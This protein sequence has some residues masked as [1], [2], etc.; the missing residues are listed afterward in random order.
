MD[1]AVVIAV[2]VARAFGA[3]LSPTVAAVVPVAPATAAAAGLDATLVTWGG[4][5]IAWYADALKEAR[6]GAGDHH[7][8]RREIVFA[9]CCA[10]SYLWEWSYGLL[11]RT[12]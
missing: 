11:R 3:A 9:V 8:R 6:V 7:E 2:P 12:G 4:F 1:G 10:E 5:A